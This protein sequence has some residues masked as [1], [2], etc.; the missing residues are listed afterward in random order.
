MNNKITCCLLLVALIAT[1]TAYNPCCSNPCQHRSICMTKGF[2]DYACDCTRTG[3]YGKN[4]EIPTL[5]QRII[6]FVKPTPD[7]THYLLTHF[8]WFWSTVNRIG[9]IRGYLMTYIYKSRGFF[10]DSPPLLN[11]DQTYIHLDAY[12]NTS[13]YTRVLPPVPKD[14]PTPMGVA[15]PKVLPDIAKIGEI[16]KRKQFKPDPMGTSLLFAFKAQHF[17]HQ[18]FKTDL[19]RGP[20]FQ[21]G[22]HG[23]DCSQ[24]YGKDLHEQNLLRSFKDGKMKT[25]IING[26]VWP[27]SVKDAPVTMRFNERIDENYRFAVGHE[28]FNLVPGI[29]MWSTIFLREHNRV[30]DLLKKEHP[31]WGDEQLYQTTKLIIIGETIK[32][33]I[34]EYVDHLGH[35]GLDLL[36]DPELLFNHQY[37]Y[38]NRIALEFNFLYH[39][40]PL[41]PDNIHI[42]GSSYSNRDFLFHPELLVKH[43]MNTFVDA[44]S[45]QVAGQVTHHNHGMATLHVALMTIQHGRELRLQSFNEYR[46][47]FNLPPFKSFREL[48]GDIET[49]DYLEAL[50]GDID[51]VE[52]YVGIIAEKR[53]Y[54][55]PFGQTMIEMG[56]PFSVKGLLSNPI[57]S[58]GWWKPSTFGGETGFNIIKT[59]TTKDLF[60]DNISGDC[61]LVRFRI[62]DWTEEK[63]D[64]MREAELAAGLQTSVKVTSRS[65]AVKTIVSTSTPKED[66]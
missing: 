43:G 50:Y 54:K 30:C 5:R 35:Y 56:A 21:W 66:L 40:H 34:E 37:Q 42:N 17:T 48:T 27:P 14:C 12:Y 57:C 7:T 23:V 3:Y 64:A 55:S 6:N 60:C 2:D 53:Q 31:E 26:E 1:A 62:P 25:Q 29:L 51:A 52:F 58:P 49:A 46:K 16:F 9:F 22:N 24:I 44:M 15:G 59:R 32:I 33:I 63:E 41:M 10:V 19:Q 8:K 39:W 36:F 65:E 13:Q 38:Q 28:F 47:R 18:F 11:S 61:G 20:A 4:C 45:R